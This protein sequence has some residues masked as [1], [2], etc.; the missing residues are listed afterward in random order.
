MELRRIL[1]SWAARS[2]V[3]PAVAVAALGATA[4]APPGAQ[5]AGEATCTDLGGGMISM[6]V[7][8]PAVVPFLD[9][10][11]AAGKAVVSVGGM[12]VGDCDLNGALQVRV[13]SA[14]GF[15]AWRV[16]DQSF[17]ADPM[18]QAHFW[19]GNFDPVL[20]VHDDP[21]GSATWRATGSSYGIDLSG[22]GTTDITTDMGYGELV[23]LG[24][25]NNDTIDL[26]PNPMQVFQGNATIKGEGGNDV[27][28][29]GAGQD[30]IEGGSG[31]DR[32][33]GWTGPD[34]LEPGSDQDEVFGRASVAGADTEDGSQDTFLV[35]IDFLPDVISGD[36]N[37]A[38]EAESFLDGVS[39]S[40]EGAGNDGAPGEGDTWTGMSVVTTGFG[41]DLINTTGVQ[42]VD[43]GAGSDTV[44]IDLPDDHVFGSGVLAE[45]GTGFDFLDLSQVTG[46]TSG[47]L[48]QQGYFDLPTA[49]MNIASHFEGLS[50]SDGVDTWT[51]DCACTAMPRGGADQITFTDDGGTFV[52]DGTPDG[53]DVVVAEEDVS[54]TADYSQRATAVS[55]TLDAEANDGA[56]GE[57][58]DLTGTT[59]LRGG[60]GADTI[61]GDAQA[62]RIE[63]G[64]GNDVLNGRGGRDVLDGD[65][66]TD[67][68]TGG[69]G[70]DRLLGGPGG[71]TLRG[72]DGDDLLRGD[73]PTDT[74]GG[75]DVLDGGAGD[76]DEFGSYGND[77]FQQGA[78]ANGQD[79]LVGGPGTDLASY[80]LRSAGVRLSL[81]GAYDD[82][83]SGEGDRINGDVE[84][85]TG[86]RGADVLTG[87]GLAN[88]LTG[89]LG[90]DTLN[91]LG[92]NDTFQA[93]DR[94]V[95]SLFGGTGTDRAHRDS[96][97]R[98]NSVEQRF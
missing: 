36:G 98:V 71:D 21:M 57:G 4:L 31:D 20:V 7:N 18:L 46:P 91:G 39:F 74:D 59:T 17:L 15:G 26:A 13:S 72:G 52:A 75:R 22:N 16:S 93:L 37:D 51:I 9:L 41:P 45:G 10:S 8:H 78:A 35:D 96:T 80:S 63:G 29:G 24:T 19:F 6:Y 34:T 83:A 5:A 48:G 84:N 87:N 49:P 43:A 2:A 62:N 77:T 40:N 88:L 44:I 60:V 97:D 42:Q 33:E 89:G 56:P 69:S 66:G 30:V 65:V 12:A 86:G 79:L 54:A 27:L 25:E 32:I 53:A 92:G 95:D 14:S 81:N 1:R 50:G 38:I 58:D 70:D 67:R 85:L 64:E 61:V 3:V 23:L 28:R 76:D 68:L 73:A 82:G 94:L 90:R 11:F 55:L 47:F